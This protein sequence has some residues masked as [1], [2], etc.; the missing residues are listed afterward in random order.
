MSRQKIHLLLFAIFLAVLIWSGIHPH[1]YFTWMLE[2]A[3]AL[4]GVTILLITYKRFELSMLLYV[5]ILIHAIILMVGGKYTYAEVPL[6]NWLQEKLGTARNSYDGIGHFAQG[7]IPAILTR[8]I[9]IRKSAIKSGKWLFFLSIC[10]PLAFS[11]FY[12]LIEW[13]VAISTGEAADAF[14]GA[15]GDPWDT[16]KDMCLCLIGSI[17]SLLLLSKAHD[18]SLAKLQS[19]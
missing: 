4:V 8:E 2:V 6:F 19:L 12:E 7:F 10:V 15:Q 13:W 9:L 18:R 16:Q 1:D 14:L 11:A 17:V 5:L 3:P